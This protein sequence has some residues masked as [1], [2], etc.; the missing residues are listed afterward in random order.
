MTAPGSA[1]VTNTGN[2][3]AADVASGRTFSSA[4]LTNVAG[5]SAKNAA[6]PGTALILPAQAFVDNISAFLDLSAH[7]LNLANKGITHLDATML[8]EWLTNAVAVN[9]GHGGDAGSFPIDLGS[10][11]LS[12]SEINAILAALKD[13]GI[14][15]GELTIS[16]SGMGAPTGQGLIDEQSLALDYGWTID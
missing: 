6:V 7:T 9:S 1:G 14:Y 10:N 13:A 2:A 4:A 15:S 5:T 16:G 8:A 12:S 3:I 11:N